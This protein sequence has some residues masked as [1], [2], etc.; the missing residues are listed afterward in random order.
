MRDKVLLIHEPFL[1]QT[2]S[3]LEKSIF[4]GPSK[5]VNDLF[6]WIV[7]GFYE[8]RKYYDYKTSGCTAECGHYEGKFWRGFETF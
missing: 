1:K 2:F 5:F 4:R 7:D 6:I 3:L 8:E